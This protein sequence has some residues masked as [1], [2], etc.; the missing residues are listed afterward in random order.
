MYGLVN[1]AVEDLVRREFGEETWLRI[2]ARANVSVPSF[3]RM[4]QYP[5]HITYDLVAAASA[6]LGMP[7]DQV[8]RT[9]GHHWIA[10]AAA[11]GYGSMFK[12]AGRDLPSFIANLDNVHAKLGI[13][14]PDMDA[15]SFAVEAHEGESSDFD[16][17]YYSSRQGLQPFVVGLLEGLAVLFETPAVVSVTATREAG[18]DHDVFRVAVAQ[19]VL[20]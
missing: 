18:A 4:Q 13:T 11:N 5:D 3:S 7:A 10:F 20:T 2:K 19:A 8:L 1:V 16:V 14:F 17:H 12:L 9:F 6:E 15:P